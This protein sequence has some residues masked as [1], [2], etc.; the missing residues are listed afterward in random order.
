MFVTFAALG[1][2]GHIVEPL[3]PAPAQEGLV[4]ATCLPLYSI[5]LALDN[6]RVDYFSLDIEGNELE[7]L[8]TIPFD[9]VD[10]KVR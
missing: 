9:K 3:E 1:H 2:V 4:N 8:K 10:I 5:L 6:P 7:V